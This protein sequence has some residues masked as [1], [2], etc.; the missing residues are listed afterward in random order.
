MDTR[1]LSLMLSC[2]RLSI[3]LSLIEQSLIMLLLVRL[4]LSR[5][6]PHGGI[7]GVG[8]LVTCATWW[9]PC[10]IFDSNCSAVVGKK[11]VEIR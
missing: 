9:Q 2:I 10:V 11:G 3:R 5:M 8:L 6:F 4:F 1:L 7:Q